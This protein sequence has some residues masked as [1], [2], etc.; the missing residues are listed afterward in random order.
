MSLGLMR[1]DRG[2]G[3]GESIAFPGGVT[4]KSRNQKQSFVI[5]TV[6]HPVPSGKWEWQ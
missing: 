2:L 6:A 4:V 3:A 1:K 5:E